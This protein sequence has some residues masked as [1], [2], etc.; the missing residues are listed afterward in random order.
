[1]KLYVVKLDYCYDNGYEQMFRVV[2]AYDT[3]EQA[4]RV[5]K[6]QRDIE[7]DNDNKNGYGM[8]EETDTTYEGWIDGFYNEDHT[9][10]EIVEVELNK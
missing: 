6:E 8:F 5:L 1:M 4:K 7:H 9:R 10:I 3:L 2:G